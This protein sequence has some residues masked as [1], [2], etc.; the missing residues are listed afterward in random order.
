MAVA[1][2]DVGDGFDVYALDLS[3]SAV[4]YVGMK[5]LEEGLSLSVTTG[6]LTDL[7]YTNGQ[8]DC[9]L[10]F[11]VLSHTDTPGMKVFYQHSS[12]LSLY[13]LRQELLLPGLI[14]QTSLIPVTVV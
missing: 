4:D 5:A 6:V 3:A 1:L 9:L 2:P 14:W 7:P 13:L 8:M 11:H 10:A 12:C